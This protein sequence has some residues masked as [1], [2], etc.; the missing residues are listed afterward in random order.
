MET[1]MADTDQKQRKV[2]LPVPN[3]RKSA[4]NKFNK[5]A[6]DSEDVSIVE[7]FCI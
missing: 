2:S 5:K 7:V 6:K 4:L 3:K 1:K